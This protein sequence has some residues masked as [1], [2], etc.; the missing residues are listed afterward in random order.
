MSSIGLSTWHP[1]VPNEHLTAGT[2][3]SKND[4]AQFMPV[5][6][7]MEEVIFRLKIDQADRRE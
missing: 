3:I 7:A 4:Y 5:F 6:I 2:F 1:S